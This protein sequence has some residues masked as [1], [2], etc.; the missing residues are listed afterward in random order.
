[1]LLDLKPGSQTSKMI[2][3]SKVLKTLVQY[4][5]TCKLMLKS[6]LQ[7]YLNYVVF[8][9][10]PTSILFYGEKYFLMKKTFS[11]VTH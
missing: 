4:F 1:V 9:Y 10:G 6:K 8:V 2:I 3:R 5:A 7:L 11:L